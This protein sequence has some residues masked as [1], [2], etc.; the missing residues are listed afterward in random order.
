LQHA[1]SRNANILGEIKGFGKHF[2]KTQN[3]EVCS[4]KESVLKSFKD[5][6]LFPKCIDLISLNANGN[7]TIDDMEAEALLHC[8]GDQLKKTD[9]IAV[10]PLVGETFGAHGAISLIRAVHLL[11]EGHSPE[12]NK[13][14]PRYNNALITSLSPQGGSAAIIIGKSN[15]E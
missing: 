3:G 14:K 8:F 15:S 7:K 11:N 2:R 4:L 6:V 13:N 5:A 1:K 12:N 10:K 9:N